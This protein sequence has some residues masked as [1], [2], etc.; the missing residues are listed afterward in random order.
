MKYDHDYLLRDA[1]KDGVCDVTT[2]RV[3]VSSFRK[4]NSGGKL[5]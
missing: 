2:S 1:N 3:I 5:L 4:R